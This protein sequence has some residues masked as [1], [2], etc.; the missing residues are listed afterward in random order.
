MMSI[1]TKDAAQKGV[2]PGIV[3]NALTLT[4]LNMLFGLFMVNCPLTRYAES[5]LKLKGM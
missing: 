3:R 2:C 1:S 4:K 5:S